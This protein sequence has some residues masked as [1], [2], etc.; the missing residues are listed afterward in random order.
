[1]RS[2][3]QIGPNAVAPDARARRAGSPG[4]HADPSEEARARRGWGPAEMGADLGDA[5]VGR[6]WGRAQARGSPGLRRRVGRERAAPTDAIG[7][8]GVEA[9]RVPA[10]RPPATPLVHRGAGW[11]GPA[12]GTRHT[13]APA[14]VARPT[15]PHRRP[16][17]MPVCEAIPRPDRAPRS[18]NAGPGPVDRNRVPR[19]LAPARRGTR[20][21]AAP[22]GPRRRRP[23]RGHGCG[24]RR[25]TGLA[26]HGAVHPRPAPAKRL[27]R[28]AR[29]ALALGR[30]AR[31]DGG[32]SSQAAAAS[33]HVPLAVHTISGSTPQDPRPAP[34]WRRGAPR[35]RPSP[36]SPPGAHRGPIARRRS[37]SAEPV[38]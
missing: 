34:T 3:A 19:I 25:R 20:R 6:E 9:R 17:A 36:A 14:E 23:R 16:R 13:S 28:G 32:R 10:L 12:A 29:A 2:A 15:D 4:A 21:T 8:R 35:R 38:P 7:A 26:D 37:A 30:H 24:A 22:E 1:M 27:P 11:R 5:D 33:A 31:C 18:V